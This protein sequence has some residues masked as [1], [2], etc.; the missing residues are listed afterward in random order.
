M[1]RDDRQRD[2]TETRTRDKHVASTFFTGGS[3]DRAMHWY[4]RLMKD[5]QSTAV[6]RCP[7]D[8]RP[9]RRRGHQVNLYIYQIIPL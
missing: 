4:S 9:T 6:D 8:V 7:I 5:L 2:Q 3:R 1:P